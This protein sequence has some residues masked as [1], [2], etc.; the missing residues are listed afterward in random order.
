M[1]QGTEDKQSEEQQ[2]SGKNWL[3]PVI[4]LV[5][6]IAAVLLVLMKPEA[7]TQEPVKP[8]PVVE[9]ITVQPKSVT[10]L[11]QTQGTVASRTSTR[12]AAEVS[13]R[14][15]KVADNF[16]AGGFF[17]KGEVLLKIE[18]ADYE[19]ALATARATLARAELALATEEAN[20]RQARDEWDSL[21]KGEP[22]T[23]A[24]R[25]PQLASARADVESAR[26]AVERAERDLKATEISVPYAGRIDD[27]MVDIGDYIT[28][29]GQALAS[30]Y[31]T[32]VAEI[33]LPVTDKQ[34][35]LLGLPFTYRND[36][37][38]PAGNRVE[39][40]ATV[41]GKDY[42]WEGIIER[43]EG[44][45]DSRSRLLYVIAQ[46]MEPYAKRAEGQPPL[47][48]GRYVEATIYG[49][50]F[51]NSY[52]IPRS[53]LVE[54]GVVLVVDREN[55]T[56]HRQ[57]VEVMQASIETAIVTSG[58]EAGMRVVV[59]PV[60]YIIEGMEVVVASSQEVPSAQDVE[61]KE[62]AE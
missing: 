24:L 11:V 45:V 18:P 21:G 10:A 53:A 19:A 37:S 47:K 52:E 38:T 5:A 60:E 31:S 62:S 49:I 43:S 26:E 58:L 15:V 48:I 40:K 9:I 59:S 28:G 14:V 33:R 50:N 8:K 1:S 7:E 41:G 17:D 35:G 20:A 27:I 30:V 23:L 12:L 25:E 13:G 61:H 39:L 2:R 56:L 29:P 34:Y 55:N 44:E 42:V 4:L 46:V 6:F 16:R 36:A 3:V 22:T 57:Q 54:P 32:D 51:E